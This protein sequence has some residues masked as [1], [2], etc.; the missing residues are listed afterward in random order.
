MPLT[1]RVLPNGIRL[2]TEPIATTKAVAI[3]F[4]FRMGS[5]DEREGEA[6][7]TH[8]AEHLLFKGTARRTSAEISR[9][10]D[11]AG[12][13]ANA[14]T[15]RE[16]TCLHCLVPATFA[17]EALSVLADM[18]WA[19]APSDSD[20]EL[21]RS[22][23]ESEILS[24]LDDPEDTGSDVAMS[25]MYPGHPIAR[26]IAGTLRDIRGIGS[27]DVKDFLSRRLGSIAPLVTVAGSFDESALESAIRELSSGLSFHEPIPEAPTPAW[28]PGRHL[29]I[30]RFG[31]S[32]LFLSYPIA[33]D[34]T[35]E[36]WFAWSMV[37]A[38]TGG[39]VGSRLFQALRERS[40][41]CYSVYSACSFGRDAA[42]WGAYAA[43]P[44]ETTAK[45]ASLLVAEM[46]TIAREGLT[47]QE[48]AD[49]KTHVIGELI[50]SA[51]DTENRMKRLARQFLFG[52]KVYTVDECVNVLE[53]IE[54]QAIHARV[55]EA[56]LPSSASLVVYSDKKRAKECERS[57]R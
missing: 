9:F 55:R 47:D 26:P 24:A 4:W 11:R 8:F 45:T 19:S 51:E 21:E 25:L 42:L 10:F 27:K 3:G 57:W 18:A 37:N 22:V 32:Q 23:I 30:S 35:V 36:D 49:A 56:F 14:F 1:E 50:L 13:Y 17:F 31:Q 44:K 46:E 34:R 7:L 41:L 40:G 28:R 52:K 12:G 54:P 6:G 20:S 39:T 43:T 16:L 48:I 15:E 33:T 38:I 5:R 53:G 2:I 29:P